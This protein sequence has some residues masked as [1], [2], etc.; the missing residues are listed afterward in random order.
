MT[1]LSLLAAL[2][3]VGSLGS[4]STAVAAPMIYGANGHA[5]EVIIADAITWNDANAAATSSIFM[6]QSG[7]LATITSLGED[8]FVEN[9]RAAALGT[10]GFADSEAWIGGFQP[11]GSTEP[12][13]GWA[14]VNGEGL[15][16]DG[17]TNWAGGEPNDVGGGE[18]FLAIG[19]NGLFG[20]NDEGNL[21]GIGGYVVE[22]SLP[23]PEPTTVT[24]L[25]LGVVSLAALRRR[26]S[27]KKEKLNRSN[28]A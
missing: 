23:V 22:Y 1:R 28:A 8:I 7:H 5:Y 6:G 14:W 18:G 15:L 21:G 2:V 26:K 19:L 25:G 20:W 24:L 9:L 12:G 3:L 27:G 16:A 10:S 11:A 17:Y 4:T 13:G